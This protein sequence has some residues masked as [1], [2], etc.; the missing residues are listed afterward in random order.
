MSGKRQILKGSVIS[1]GIVLGQTKLIVPGE[2]QIAEM[3]IPASRVYAEVDALDKAIEETIEELREMRDS[4]DKSIGNPVAKIFDAQLL[5]A[6]DYEFLKQVKSEIAAHRRNAGY[7]YNKLVK[8]TLIH[9]QSSPDTYMQQT[10]NDIESVSR[11]VL[12]HLSGY[13]DTHTKFQPNTILI[14]RKF[15]PGD[16][17]NYRRR[18]ATGFVI[19]EGGKNSHMALITRGL[20]MPVLLVEN[21][22]VKIPDN[23]KII[24][25]GPN[26]QI[27]LNPTDD[28]WNNY[29]KMKKRFGPALTTRIKRLSK[30]PPVT[31]DGKEIHIGANLALPGPVDE[32]LT[33]HKI[34]VGLYRT[35]FMYLTRYD[36]PDE[37]TQFAF[38]S[39]IAEHYKKTSVTLRTFDVGYDKQGA[40]SRWPNEDN[41]ALGWRGIRPLLEMTDI[42]KTQIR[43][44]L[45]A[46]TNKNLK[47][48]LPMIT[49]AGEIDQAKKL[50]QQV[51][52]E[53][54]KDKI[55]FDE[56]IELGI[57]IEVPSAAMMAEELA[58]KVDFLSIG[59][60]DLTQYTLA[61]DRMNL[62]VAD[63][64]NTF[65]PAVLK[66]ICRTVKAAQKCAI[67]VS[68]CG[69]I[70]GDLLALPLFIGMGI[71]LLSMNPN[72]IF[73][74][75]RLVAKIDYDMARHLTESVINS[76]TLGEV[77]VKLQSYKDSLEK[78]KPLSK[79]K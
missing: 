19:S 12:S 71:D 9:L 36:F 34:P 55:P 4:A 1:G 25:D 10:A 66:M 16:I 60:N 44:I 37:E 53:L 2:I 74:I 13:K 62:K 64:Y 38:Y 26:A 67:P 47:I 15:S 20:M 46:S 69:E 65:H 58:K 27:I 31:T 6:S 39:E 70:A 30:V 45:R 79:R 75:C 22:L 56:N 59:T 35:E 43:A 72:R 5:I 24:I 52:F 29:Q 8:K 21:A 33:H 14:S 63:L 32:V 7:I 28:E 23:T 3:I 40:N 17:M 48:M 77:I 49:D 42:F 68:I 51:K 18:K 54:K 50:I 73:D 76:E 41:P 11:R 78:K 57:M 61:V